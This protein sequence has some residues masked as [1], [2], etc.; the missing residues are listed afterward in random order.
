MSTN[1]LRPSE[2]QVLDILMS[3][4]QQEEFY[5]FHLVRTQ[6]AVPED[7]FMQVG[8][9]EYEI[10]DDLAK[11]PA[12][13]LSPEILEKYA[14]Q[15]PWYQ[16]LLNPAIAWDEA[17]ITRFY[18][19]IGHDLERVSENPRFQFTRELGEKYARQLDWNRL[20]RNQGDF[21]TAE[22]I[23]AFAEHWFWPY[24]S[25]NPKIPFTEALIEQF[26]EQWDWEKLFYN[27]VSRPI[28]CQRA[29]F[30]KYGSR[31]GQRVKPFF[32]EDQ[33]PAWQ[34]WLRLT[35]PEFGGTAWE[36]LSKSEKE[37]QVQAYLSQYE[38]EINLNNFLHRPDFPWTPALVAQYEAKIEDWAA[39]CQHP[40]FPL[41]E[42]FLQK[43][44]SKLN[45]LS[46]FRNPHLPWTPALLSTYADQWRHT[47]AEE[48]SKNAR[49]D[50]SCLLALA[51]LLS[52][53]HL[54]ENTHLPWT[55]AL[56]EKFADRWHW[57]ALSDNPA[58]PWSEDFIR[59]YETRWHWGSI[60]RTHYT[61]RIYGLPG[62]KGIS[63]SLEL[64]H[65]FRDRI[66]LQCLADSS[67]RDWQAQHLYPAL[68]E[69]V[70]RAFLEKVKAS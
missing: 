58:L 51:D 61:P 69:G 68:T 33:A 48:L 49:L 64:I 43:Y 70:V 56:V 23:A 7:C 6:G 25:Q 38:P 53:P 52:W 50:E 55:P 10:F 3:I 59:Q 45:W 2:Q 39:L 17:L 40:Q 18:A 65:A 14:E 41:S 57:P 21:W 11:N 67:N 26:A 66:E 44:E 20:G 32:F 22:I 13:N 62:N 47:H 16:L 4:H 9:D 24:L 30:E 15:W 46:L 37:A 34:A 36:S 60:Q 54:S 27:P 8:Q 12:L 19:Y 29:F 5:S 31:Y 1:A 42:D 35:Q 63:W 28:L